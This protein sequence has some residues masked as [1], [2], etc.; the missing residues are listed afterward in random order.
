MDRIEQRA[1]EWDC[2]QNLSRLFYYLDE[3]R[4]ADLAKLFAPDGGSRRLRDGRMVLTERSVHVARVECSSHLFS[5][6]AGGSSGPWSKR[7]KE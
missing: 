7:R 1:M 2:H 4:Y 6:A 3:G 5:R